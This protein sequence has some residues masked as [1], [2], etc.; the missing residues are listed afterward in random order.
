M[1]KKYASLETLRTF[2]TKLTDL[3]ATKTEMEEKSSVQMI[4]VGDT[5]STV[6]DIST[7]K[8]HK[9][10]QEQYD[11]QLAN[12]TIDE[13]AIYLTPNEE[14]DLSVYATVEQL[15][16]K[17]D[18][19][20][21]HNISDI[22]NLQTSLDEIQISLNQ[23]VSTDRTING[24]A[25]SSNI[26]L[27]ASDVGADPSGSA[28]NA[29]SQANEYTDSVK[30][31]LLNGAGGAYDTL[32]E[33]GDLID[34]NT[35]AIDALE[36]IAASKADKTHNHDDVYYTESEVDEILS[37]HTHSYDDLRNKPFYEGTDYSSIF[38]STVNFYDWGSGVYGA[39]VTSAPQ[40]FVQDISHKVIWDGVEYTLTSAYA[41]NNDA[42]NPIVSLGAPY[43]DYSQYPFGIDSYQTS[44]GTYEYS[45]HTNSTSSTH[46]ID[47]LELGSSFVTLDDRFISDNIARTLD[48]DTAI[49]ELNTN[50]ADKVHNHSISDVTD[51]QTTLDTMNENLQ[52]NTWYGTCSTA[53]STTDKVVTTASGDFSLE[54]GS[55]VYI[56]FTYAS[57]TNATL[58]VDGTGAKTIKI[59]GNNNVS[60]YH[61]SLNEVVGFV[62]DG[63]YFRMLDGQVASTTYYGV[64]KL[65]SS[66][67]ST[68]TT[69]AA[70]PSAVKAAYDLANTANTNAATAQEGVNGLLV[71]IDEIKDAKADW[72]QNDSSSIDYIK[73]RTH[74]ISEGSEV[75]IAQTTETNIIN[76]KSGWTS[77]VYEPEYDYDKEYLVTVDGV[78]YRCTP[79]STYD[80]WGSTFFSL[81]D[82][83]LFEK[84]NDNDELV[85]DTSHPEDVP[86]LV[87]AW[88][89]DDGG[90][91]YTYRHYWAI[92]YSTTG[93]HT[94]EIAEL[95]GEDA[96][97]PLDEGFIPDTIA[98]TSDTEWSLI[99]D[100][101][102]ITT[103]VNSIAN[104]NIAGYKNIQVVAQN[105][106][107][108]TNTSSAVGAIKFTSSNG[109]NYLFPAWASF[110]QATSGRNTAGM[111]HFKL[112]NGWLMLEHSAASSAQTNDV[113]NETEGGS[114]F[115]CT[116][117]SGSAFIRCSNELS[118]MAITSQNQSTSNYLGVGSRVMVWGCRA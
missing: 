13:N 75:V 57:C 48:V 28:N 44:S 63:T 79:Y 90:S 69:T 115:K 89:E 8:I 30:N 93:T 92:L 80:N 74:W 12:G 72:N 110:F 109:T 66:T 51:L 46:T 43:G 68:S 103:A 40:V 22:N 82:S 65:S 112:L 27:S 36:I 2:L 37:T 19:E 18:T 78:Q 23:K 4:T 20:H 15:G 45:I 11:E 9:L 96:Y 62:Y 54:V 7:L 85:S 99:Y 21:N 60:T 49:N 34:E 3:F 107:D 26:T 50:K 97:H 5:E 95:T 91:G 116:V 108:G 39:A 86:F 76:E 71:N 64:T 61:W 53:A 87:Q 67:S 10:T 25:L 24:K 41:G 117:H 77:D 73:N 98:R 33:L 14:V 101:D 84:L 118:T 47:I 114:A 105:T 81:G 55:I 94:I 35:D 56:L 59:V 16:T 83:R 88:V 42:G 70:T 17:A 6:E 52:N 1:A 104:I 113:F 58:N 106:N 29:L 100:S 38:A 102:E 32:K 31:D 111:A